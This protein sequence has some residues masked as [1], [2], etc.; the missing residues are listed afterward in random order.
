MLSADL[1][2]S[3]ARALVFAATPLVGAEHGQRAVHAG[4]EGAVGRRPD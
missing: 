3:F 2:V 1:D 4:I